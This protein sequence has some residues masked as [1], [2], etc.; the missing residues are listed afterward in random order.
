MHRARS[1]ARIGGVGPS[2]HPAEA[3]PSQASWR[4][5]RGSTTSSAAARS[6]A[7]SG[8]RPCGGPGGAGWGPWV[9]QETPGASEPV[10]RARGG[11]QGH[12]WGWEA[13]GHQGYWAGQAR[14][15]T[16]SRVRPSALLALSC[17]YEFMR[18]SLIFY[19]N[20]IQKMTGKVG[21][22][23]VGVC[24][25]VGGVVPVAGLTTAPPHPHRTPWSS[26]A[27]PRRPGSS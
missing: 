20:E 21:G 19:R 16:R 17:S 25:C 27:Y 22:G 6:S 1:Q 12:G 9:G 5:Q 10:G 14:G 23:W 15:G 18:R 11:E 8:R 3:T 26:S 2:G 13:L 7:R 24:V 4:T